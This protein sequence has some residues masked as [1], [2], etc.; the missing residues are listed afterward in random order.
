MAISNDGRSIVAASSSPVI[1]LL[2]APASFGQ[3][4]DGAEKW[5]CLWRV[6]DQCANNRAEQS[7]ETTRWRERGMRDNSWREAMV[8]VCID[9]P[10]T[11]ISGS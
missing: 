8:F 7:H 4:G 6:V 5:H 9:N 11:E 10:I 2:Y 1:H 3:H